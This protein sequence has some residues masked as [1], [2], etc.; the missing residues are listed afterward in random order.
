MRYIVQCRFCGS[1]LFKTNDIVA[2][3]MAIEIKCPQCKKI[4]KIPENIVI[5]VDKRKKKI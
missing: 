2:G 4:I 3:V 1:I 5:T